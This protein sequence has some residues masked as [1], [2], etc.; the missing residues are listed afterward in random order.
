MKTKIMYIAAILCALSAL[1]FA[2]SP[3]NKIPTENTATQPPT[4]TPIF[5]PRPIATATLSPSTL[6]LVRKIGGDPYPLSMPANIAFDTKGDVYVLD[7]GNDRV[8]VFDS[9]GKFITLWGSKGS[10]DGQFDLLVQ[11]DI[12]YT[13][14][15]IALD[16][17][18]NI[19]VA[20]GLNQRVQKFDSSGKFL[21]KWGDPGLGDGHFLRPLDLAIDGQGNIY[22]VDDRGS[23]IQKF[24]PNGNFILKFGEEGSGDGQLDNTGGITVGNDGNLYIAD[25]GNNRV[26]VFG[27]D[28]K[29]LRKWLT[30][31]KKVDDIAVDSKGNIFTTHEDGSVVEYDPNGQAI[32][33]MKDLGID[34]AGGIAIDGKGLVY[35]TDN[36][37]IDIFQEK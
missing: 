1:L 4:N 7:A 30:P 28:G 15:G 17:N 11:E 37:G 2:C 10:G 34:S 35:I 19:F 3:Q 31:V 18:N 14:G 29:Y 21:M 32:S 24:D 12:T 33:I 5:T 22:V 9:S 36:T 27:P 23:D 16:K 25:Y 8:Q 20:D 6:V 13:I 26:E